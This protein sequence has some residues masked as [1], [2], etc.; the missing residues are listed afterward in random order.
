[1]A[2]GPNL[3]TEQVPEEGVVPLVLTP[4]ADGV[5]LATWG[6]ANRD[7]VQSKL[8][9][10][11]AILFRGF[12]VTVETFAACVKALSGELIQNLEESSPRR[13]LGSNIFTSTDYPRS[14][15]IFPH[16]EWS[17]ARI[18][19][20]KLFF[21]CAQ[22]AE[23]GGATPLVDIRKVGDR[24]PAEIKN[25]FECA[26]YRYVRNYGDG[27]N[28]PWQKAFNT[29][30]QMEVEKYCSENKIEYE[31]KGNGRLRTW[32]VRPVS[33][34]HPQTGDHIWFNHA[35]FFHISTLDP[36]IQ[37]GLLAAFDQAELPNNTYY[38]DG[39]PIEPEVMKELQHAYQD[40]MVRFKWEKGDLV[41]IDNMLAAHARDP[42]V[43][44]RKIL[45]AMTEPQIQTGI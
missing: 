20:L 34:P 33:T 15:S 24:I 3:V 21:Y 40:N 2:D 32:Q 8:L 9:R 35:T 14:Q 38:G 41:M 45:F 16:N 11:A 13:R 30:V 1:M 26:K 42:Y 27:M 25:R 36:V 7:Y 6:L 18:Y 43:G 4:A 19:P 23:Q 31:W 29:E 37:K 5:D 39:K 44:D 28:I 12:R 22:P 17:Y 10:H